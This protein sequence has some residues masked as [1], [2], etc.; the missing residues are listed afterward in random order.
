LTTPSESYEPVTSQYLHIFAQDV[1]S[2]RIL[3][4]VTASGGHSNRAGYFLD[5]AFP[6]AKDT[7]YK[8]SPSVNQTTY[9][10]IETWSFT[11]R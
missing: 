6:T 4:K 10:E 11:V 1:L 8:D 2:L 9:K 3:T 5:N 7:K